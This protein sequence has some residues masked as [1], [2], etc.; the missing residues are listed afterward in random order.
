MLWRRCA[1]C[2]I[3][4]RV[5]DIFDLWIE[6]G[7][8]KFHNL[9]GSCIDMNSH[10]GSFSFVFFFSSRRRH[11]RFDCDWSSDVCSSDLCWAR[12]QVSSPGLHTASTVDGTVKRNF[13]E[14]RAYVVCYMTGFKIS[15]RTRSDQRLDRKSVV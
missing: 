13:A 6:S 1:G 11:T 9:G 2:S 3:R 14:E 5:D 10:A 12:K 7:D 8:E 4:R 15:Q